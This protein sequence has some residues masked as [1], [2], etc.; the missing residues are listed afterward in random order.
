MKKGDQGG[1]EYDLS[2]CHGW[3]FLNELLSHHTRLESNFK[4]RM[5]LA[6][7][8]IQAIF[9]HAGVARAFARLVGQR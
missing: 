2:R 9:E 7:T 5:S 3:E 1:F 8:G 6:P 4:R